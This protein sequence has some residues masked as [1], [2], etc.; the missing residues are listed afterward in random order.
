MERNWNITI[1]KELQLTERFTSPA[2]FP[3]DRSSFYLFVADIE[4]ESEYAPAIFSKTY[5]EKAIEIAH[6]VFVE[7]SVPSG[8]RP[9]VSALVY[10]KPIYQNDNMLVIGYDAETNRYYFFEIIM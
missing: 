3:G 7:A 6:R 8:I 4:L 9:D 2:S 10:R 5:Q 1:P